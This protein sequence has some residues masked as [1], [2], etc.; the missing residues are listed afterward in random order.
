MK[1]F[2]FISLFLL[3]FH[4]SESLR[5]GI[6][7]K[8][9]E[10]VPDYNDK[11]YYLDI[12]DKM[13][14]SMSTNNCTLF[15]GKLPVSS[16]IGGTDNRKNADLIVKV[17]PPKS[18]KF[19]DKW[20]NNREISVY[21]KANSNLCNC[22]HYNKN[23]KTGA[24]RASKGC[25]QMLIDDPTTGQKIKRV[26]RYGATLHPDHIRCDVESA[27][28]VCEA[29]LTNEN[30]GL[31]QVPDKFRNLNAFPFVMLAKNVVVSNSGM[32]ALQCGP[33]GLLSSCEAVN[34]GITTASKSLQYVE[35]CRSNNAEQ[36][37]LIRHKRIFLM[38]QY[39]DTQ[40]G[41]F[42]MES[43]PRL[44]YHIDYL[45]ANPDIMIH[46]GF[47]KQPTIP[48]F[49][50]PL[51]YLRWLGFGD[52]VINGTYYADEIIMAREGGCQDAGY[53][54]WEVLYM[55]DK[56]IS[57][58]KLETRELFHNS[59]K[60]NI[61]VLSRS[62]AS[63]YM[64]NKSDGNVRRWPTD[65]LSLFLPAL[66]MQY[67]NTHNVA[68]FSDMN[69]TLMSNPEEQIKLFRNANIAIGFHGAGLTNTMY[70][71]PGSIV[72]EIIPQF[73]SRHASLVGIF[74]RLSGIVGL[75][76]Y[77]YYIKDI[78]LDANKLV[79]DIYEFHQNALLLSKYNPMESEY[80]HS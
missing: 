41:Q 4:L 12:K 47:T 22:K 45:K 30:F 60:P 67:G 46:F 57:M 27:V 53:N 66:E 69:T 71:R 24:F 48:E 75:H 34:W 56:F 80:F 55:R 73:D 14:E 68:L 51:I 9:D 74:P 54:A 58:L 37:P 26:N 44:V 39:D 43:F 18:R 35:P 62:S 36:C 29:V 11:Y 64:Q 40:I 3:V 21:A 6:Q 16:T 20:Q 65:F 2:S 49:V 10:F 52:R 32:L 72:V 70:M 50:L 15:G 28:K 1:I 38:S 63:K 17:M 5:Q 33:F 78:T 61:V 31:V 42:M 19:L 8:N 79:Q 13:I 59:I 25:F 23:F 77:S 7:F 76:H